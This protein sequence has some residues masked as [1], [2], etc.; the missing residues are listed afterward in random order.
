MKGTGKKSKS[1]AWLILLEGRNY[2]L[3]GQDRIMGD[4]ESG[5]LNR[6]C[7]SWGR[8]ALKE[9]RIFISKY[10]KDSHGKGG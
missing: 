2:Y 10:L 9:D 8:E 7:L 1:L 4:G 6:K 3:V 5:F